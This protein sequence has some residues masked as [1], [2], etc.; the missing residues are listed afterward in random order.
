MTAE[1]A[2]PH[3]I[4]TP[5]VPNLRDLGG[6]ATSDGGEVARGV[7]FRSA[8]LDSPD[9]PTDP[10]LS[11][12][13][14]RTVVDLRT[15]GER[16][17]RPDLLPDG[18]RSLALDVLAETAQAAAARS[19]TAQVADV[20]RAP[21]GVVA[22]FAGVDAAARMRDTYRDLVVAPGALTAYR[23]LVDAVLDPAGVPVLFHC[24]AGKDRTG[25]GATV[26]LLAAG[27][28]EDGAMEEFLAVN[29]AVRATFAPMLAQLEADGGDP[30]VLA[31]LLEVRPDYLT[32]AFDAMRERFGS[33]DAYLSDGLGLT[34]LRAEALRNVLRAG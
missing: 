18:A 32:A 29:P 9:V 25:W 8:T 22:A 21:G 2:D 33:F 7:V 12:L 15:A 26:L 1:I 20:A 31:P 13:G 27:V 28:D 16:A 3:V 6:R 34:P 23:G 5:A 24:T 30:T 10:V 19:G 17:T 11:A 4:V 14:I